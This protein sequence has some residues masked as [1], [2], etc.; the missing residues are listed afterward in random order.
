[1]TPMILLDSSWLSQSSDNLRGK[2]EAYD[3][4]SKMLLLGMYSSSKWNY[5]G[6]MPGLR[7]MGMIS[8]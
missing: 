4:G 3:F 5:P 2:W 8:V 7:Y 1:M 6:T